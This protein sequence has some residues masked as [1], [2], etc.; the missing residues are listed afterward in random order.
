MKTFKPRHQFYLPDD[1][2]VKLNALTASPGTSKTQ[3]LT[4]A[5]NAWLV[6]TQKSRSKDWSYKTW[7]CANF[8]PSG[9]FTTVSR[10][11]PV[12]TSLGAIAFRLH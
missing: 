4:D 5:L 1:L 9:L 3:I 8:Q 6:M 12:T 2:S 10:I 7:R 11:R